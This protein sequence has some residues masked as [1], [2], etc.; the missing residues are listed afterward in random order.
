MLPDGSIILSYGSRTD[1]APA[2]YIKINGHWMD[3]CADCSDHWYGADDEVV[4]RVGPDFAP[5]VTTADDVVALLMHD[6]SI[7]AAVRAKVP[8]LRELADEI[9][10]I[11]AHRT[12]S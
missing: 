10:R 2:A 12:G 5:A 11:L 9:E 3:D 6:P 7:L 1:A 4:A 8:D